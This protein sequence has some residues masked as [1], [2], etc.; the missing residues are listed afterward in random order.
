M[1]LANVKVPGGSSLDLLNDSL[2]FRFM[3]S[4]E[5]DYKYINELGEKCYYKYDYQN[6]LKELL[7]N[8]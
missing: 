5:S 4:I 2:D 7:E 8:G 1:V 3:S 6:S